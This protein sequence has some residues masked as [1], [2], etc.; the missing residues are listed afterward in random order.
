MNEGKDCTDDLM[1]C[2]T[3]CDTDDKECKDACVDEYQECVIPEEPKPKL[4]VNKA[5][6][7]KLVKQYKK[8]KKNRKSNFSQIKKLG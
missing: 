1:D 4:S 6:I 3:A 2:T 8:I 7:A 5:E